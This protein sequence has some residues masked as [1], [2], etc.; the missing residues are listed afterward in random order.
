M[1]DKVLITVA[2][3]IEF[4]GKIP[5]NCEII[6]RPHNKTY[7]CTSYDISTEHDQLGYDPIYLREMLIRLKDDIIKTNIF[8]KW[9][10]K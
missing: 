6:Y 9:D 5:E 7:K 8:K 10:W 1:K 3:K 2:L 4:Q